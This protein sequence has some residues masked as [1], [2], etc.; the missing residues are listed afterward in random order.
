MGVILITCPNTGVEFSTGIHAD[1]DTFNSL[2]DVLVRSHCPHCGLQHNWW[3]REARLVDSI[4]PAQW[5]EAKR[6]PWPIVVMRD[7]PNDPCMPSRAAND[8]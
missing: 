2:A 5:V 1:A 4:E 6:H 7:W 8:R 3:K